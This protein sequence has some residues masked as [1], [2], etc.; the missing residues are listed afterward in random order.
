[1]INAGGW[2]KER[3]EEQF[4][5][6][7]NDL[8]EYLITIDAT[9][10]QQANDVDFCALIEHELY[11]IAHK[12]DEWGIPS[13]NRETGKPKLTIQGHDVKSSRVLFAVME[14]IRKFKKWLMLQIK[15]L[16]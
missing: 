11:H 4:Y 15:V 2:K 5:Q 6:W 10:A 12:K 7:F 16:R 9:Y 13:Y 1:M 8:P 3:Q 14:Q